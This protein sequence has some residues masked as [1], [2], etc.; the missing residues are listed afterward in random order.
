MV[1]SNRGG[2]TPAIHQHLAEPVI[3]H[4]DEVFAVGA[5]KSLQAARD[6]DLRGSDLHLFVRRS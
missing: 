2:A 6:V 1:G 3:F 5:A 4:E